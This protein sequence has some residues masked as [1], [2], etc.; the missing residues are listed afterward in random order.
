MDQA[1]ERTRAAIDRGNLLRAYDIAQGALEEEPD[2]RELQYLFV[3][4]AARMGNTE[5]AMELCQQ[6]GF[7]QSDNVDHR[8]IVA[9][10][11]KDS[12]LATEEPERRR[13]A[14]LQAHLA[15]EEVFRDTGDAFPGINAATMALLAGETDMA[16]SL[17]GSILDLPD[18]AEPENFYDCAT[19]AEARFV[20]G[21]LEAVSEVLQRAGQMA[22]ANSGAKSSTSKQ[23]GLI[24]AQLKLD[25]VE[26]A[27]LLRPILPPSVIHFCGHIFRE[28]K[29]I[30]ARL[31]REIDSFVAE[32]D[33]GFAYGSLAAGSDM[34]IAEAVLERGGEIHIT[35]PFNR[36]D[37]IAQSIEP[38]GSGWLDRFEKCLEQASSVN[39][40]T[41]MNYVGDPAQF[42]YAS[43][44]AMGM[45]RLRAQFL[46]SRIEQ[47]AIWDG[48]ASTGPAGTGADVKQWEA[49]GGTTTVIAADDIDRHTDGQ[50]PPAEDRHKRRLAALLFTDFQG[51]S[52]L[53][54]G[55]LPNFWQLIMGSMATVL[56]RRSEHIL[57]KNS[58]GDALHAVAGDA[59]SAAR[60]AIELQQALQ[61]I[62][63]GLLGLNNSGGMRIGVHYGSVYET[64]DP[65]TANPNFFGSEVS[66]AA[67]IEPVTPPG[68]VF[69]TEPFAAILALEAPDEFKCRYVGNIKFAKDY[70]SYPI[71]RLSDR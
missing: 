29:D 62:D 28:D 41:E 68:A 5:L 19:H 40:A 36:D 38:A 69:V 65:I 7:A 12:A 3:L 32:H 45:A 55:A 15:Y 25:E 52:K 63:F 17:A 34:L 6:Y 49:C 64:D 21:E 30:E 2:N 14:L 26:R 70:G 8:A 61:E 44:V 27:S 58:W 47:L 10:I 16:H 50:E 33:I 59:P 18:V 13:Q 48:V 11:L 60:I 53:S 39:F 35:L 24:A 54:E 43:S 1:I 37:F 22:D 71:Y 31:R 51:F 67:R 57:A 4:A 56:Q 9:R 42:S 66:R 23:L 20:L 46:G